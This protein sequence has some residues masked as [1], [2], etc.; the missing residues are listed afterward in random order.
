VLDNQRKT[1]LWR[2]SIKGVPRPPSDTRSDGGGKREN[3]VLKAL[4]SVKGGLLKGGN[5]VRGHTIIKGRNCEALAV[6]RLWS[7]KTKVIW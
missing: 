6:E 7:K 3:K 1:I 2:K 5:G 4:A